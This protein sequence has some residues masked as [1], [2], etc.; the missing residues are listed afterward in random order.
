MLLASPNEFALTEQRSQVSV[1]ENSYPITGVSVAIFDD[2]DR[3]LIQFRPFPP[4]W[5][6]PG[7]HVPLGET[8]IDAAARETREETG[9]TVKE[10]GLVGVFSWHL[11]RQLHDAVYFSRWSGRAP[12]RSLEAWAFRFVEP[13]SLP[14]FTFPWHQQRIADALSTLKG[15]EPVH[16]RQKVKLVDILR[17]GAIIFRGR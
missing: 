12:Q 3:V 14:A 1:G 9:M 11:H 4:G 5:E 17:A 8:P 6:L 16:R 15:A 10:L 7:G 13:T 2:S